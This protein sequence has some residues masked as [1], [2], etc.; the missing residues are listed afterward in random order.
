MKN[1][2]KIVASTMLVLSLGVVNLSAQEKTSTGS[3]DFTVGVG[4]AFA[5]AGAGAVIKVPMNINAG[6]KLRVEPE[7]SLATNSVTVGNVTTSTTNFYLGSGVYMLTPISSKINLLYGGKLAYD[8][9]SEGLELA[10][11]AGFEYFL[12]EDTLSLGADAGYQIDFANNA[13]SGTVSSVTL[14]LYF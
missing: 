6:V 13:T 14:R 8:T 1:I 4:V 10:A 9:G 5:N 7:V 3:D 11:L 2:T 12:L